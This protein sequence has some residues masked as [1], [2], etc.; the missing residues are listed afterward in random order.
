[1]NA[2]SLKRA[3]G[4]TVAAVSTSGTMMLAPMAA[5]AATARPAHTHTV[6]TASNFAKAGN[7][8][9]TWRTVRFRTVRRTTYRYW[10]AYG[11]RMGYRYV[12]VNG[13]RTVC[14]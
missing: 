7:G 13:Y 10:T 2:K 3:L 14:R 1:M 12:T 6:S 11:P 5:N 4:L 9:C 8:S